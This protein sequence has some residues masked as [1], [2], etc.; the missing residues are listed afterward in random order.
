MVVDIYCDGGCRGNGKEESVGAFGIVV[1]LKNGDVYYVSNGKRN[2]TN[3]EMELNGLLES[4]RIS[5]QLIGIDEM[6]ET[7]IYCDSAYALNVTTDWMWKWAANGWTKKGG[8]IKNKELI[9]LIYDELNFYTNADRIS[10]IKVKGHAGNKYNEEADR[11]LN[12]F[13]DSNF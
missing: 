13:M 6:M 4:I 1:V 10:F 9:Q 8:E 2:T 11:I 3:N 5:K 7:K 12:D